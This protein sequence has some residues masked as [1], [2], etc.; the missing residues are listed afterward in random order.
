MNVLMILARVAAIL[1][2]V[3]LCASAIL[4]IVD[5]SLGADDPSWVPSRPVSVA[6]SAVTLAYAAV[7]ITPPR[8][9]MRPTLFYPALVLRL[10][11]FAIFAV[12]S[13]A[14]I[15]AQASSF[16]ALLFLLF[17]PGALLCVPSA[18]SVWELLY[19]RHNTRHA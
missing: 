12:L 10:L 1:F 2:A 18:L 16:P 3:G 4:G 5:P 14:I 19:A 11:A 15:R 9:F 17:I 7:L 13:V 8:Y 6:Q